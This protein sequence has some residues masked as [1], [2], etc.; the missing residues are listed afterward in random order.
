MAKA[1]GMTMLTAKQVTGIR[2]QLRDQ[3]DQFSEK[4]L[5]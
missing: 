4:W 1:V 5:M 3:L 2:E